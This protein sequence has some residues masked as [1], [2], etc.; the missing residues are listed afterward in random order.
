MRVVFGQFAAEAN[1]GLLRYIEEHDPSSTVTVWDPLQFGES[2][3]M[4]RDAR[5]EVVVVNTIWLVQR[6]VLWQILVRSGCTSSR[7][8]IASPRVTNEMKIEVAFRGYFDVI[9]TGL[10][11]PLAFQR[12]R[13]IAAGSSSLDSDPL[14]NRV[15][16]PKPRTDGVFEAKDELDTS[17]LNLIRMGYGDLDISEIVGLSAQTVRN[18]VSSLLERN[19][20]DNRTHLALAY[21][22]SLLEQSILRTLDR[23]EG[24]EPSCF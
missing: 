21:T 13:E 24:M 17:I 19:G 3:A 7:V 20:L 5:P 11:I 10:A 1:P 14:W 12:L 23:N 9:D 2:V 16:R 6:P 4:L 18:R 22:N 15:P 8:V